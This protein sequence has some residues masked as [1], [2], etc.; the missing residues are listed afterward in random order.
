M[1]HGGA[2]HNAPGVIDA[3][4]LLE[5]HRLTPLAPLHQPHALGAI[6][7]LM[8][9]HPA[10]PQIACFDTAFHETLSLV[11]SSFVLPR[12]LRDEGLRRYG[13]YGLSYEY[14]ALLGVPAAAGRVVMAHLGPLDG[15]PMGTRCGAIDPG[16]VLYLL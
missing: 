3:D 11:G 4:V 8:R 6:S 12:A 16:A 15:L 14:I 10:L 7:A 2:R 9:S 13:F 5:L 1:V